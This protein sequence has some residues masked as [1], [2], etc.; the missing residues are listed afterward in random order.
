MEEGL[1]GRGSTC[2]TSPRGTRIQA[3]VTELYCTQWQ[4]SGA[5]PILQQW[6][7]EIA[8]GKGNFE[9]KWVGEGWNPR[10][11]G[12]WPVGRSVGTKRGLW[13][14]ALALAFQDGVWRTMTSEEHWA[15]GALGVASLQCWVFWSPQSGVRMASFPRVLTW[16][17]P[18][19]DPPLWVWFSHL[20]AGHFS[21]GGPSF[22]FPP[23]EDQACWS[24]G[25]VAVP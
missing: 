17:Y 14:G 11:Q 3:Q 23:A 15:V 8:L 13:P 22:S 9:K 1:D 18:C 4:R 21:S 2:C 24:G 6:L 10:L 5:L 16:V 7:W 20:R 25:R 12:R 19:P